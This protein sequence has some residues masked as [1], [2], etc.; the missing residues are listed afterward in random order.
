MLL[1]GYVYTARLHKCRSLLRAFNDKP[2]QPR[3]LRALVLQR[4]EPSVQGN[5]RERSRQI[6]PET[7]GKKVGLRAAP[8]RQRQS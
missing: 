4:P 8:L 2:L 3:S 7:D 6:D 1:V 5:E